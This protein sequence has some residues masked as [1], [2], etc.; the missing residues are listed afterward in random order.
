[1]TQMPTDL[2]QVGAVILDPPVA[3]NLAVDLP[4]D[5]TNYCKINSNTEKG[6]VL[7]LPMCNLKVRMAKLMKY[8]ECPMKTLENTWSAS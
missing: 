6:N 5:G 3:R 1:M 8:Q 2:W 7:L 4:G